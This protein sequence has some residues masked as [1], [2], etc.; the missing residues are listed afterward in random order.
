VAESV[1]LIPRCNID[2]LLAIEAAPTNHSSPLDES[3]CVIGSRSKSASLVKPSPLPPI[4]SSMDSCSVIASSDGGR[5]ASSHVTI[6]SSLPADDSKQTESFFMTEVCF[7]LWCAVIWARLHL[8]VR[9][10][11]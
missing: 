10:A 5:P 1:A 6:T 11:A 8:M 4:R 9:C 7:Y 3:V 2:D